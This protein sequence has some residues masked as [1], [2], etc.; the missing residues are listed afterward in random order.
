MNSCSVSIG[1]AVNLM[2]AYWIAFYMCTLLYVWLNAFSFCFLV[3]FP[4]ILFSIGTYMQSR[5]S[6]IAFQSEAGLLFVMCSNIRAPPK[7]FLLNS[8]SKCP[9]RLTRIQSISQGNFA[10]IQTKSNKI[11]QKIRRLV[12]V[13]SNFC[14][15]CHDCH[16]NC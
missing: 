4:L 6:V 2:S 16:L 10:M 5:Q 11:I 7:S 12:V 9:D 8:V 13:Y 1:V 3:C 15:K 14:W